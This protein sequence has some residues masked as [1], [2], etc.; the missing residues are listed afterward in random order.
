MTH[1]RPLLLTAFSL[2]LASCQLDFPGVTGMGEG[3]TWNVTGTG[4][5][6][7]G[8]QFDGAPSPGE[9][10]PLT[11]G[12]AAIVSTTL[13]QPR[14]DCATSN[15]F[16]RLEW[17]ADIGQTQPFVQVRLASCEACT[18]LFEGYRDATPG[19]QDGVKGA[20]QLHATAQRVS[21]EVVGVQPG[22]G[23][24][25]VFDCPGEYCTQAATAHL[26]FWVA[27]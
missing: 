14:G 13:S 2:G 25:H 18:L 21:F 23:T 11:V 20:A 19:R 4:C 27:S 10:L 16:V 7:E 26:T 3:A 17:I 6:L 5:Y 12:R 22:R 8:I 15:R 1:G 24:L 9:Y